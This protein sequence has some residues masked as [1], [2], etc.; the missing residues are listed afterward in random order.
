MKEAS[1]GFYYN[2]RPHLINACTKGLALKWSKFLRSRGVH[3]EIH[4]NTS[5]PETL[6]PILFMYKHITTKCTGPEK[7]ELFIGFLLHN[8]VQLRACAEIKRRI[9]N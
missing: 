2:F 9:V 3:I 8:F 5:C 6:I 7:M 1:D 4:I